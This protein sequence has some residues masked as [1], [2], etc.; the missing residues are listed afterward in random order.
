MK[1]EIVLF[2]IRCKKKKQVGWVGGEEIKRGKYPVVL[3][4]VNLTGGH[5]KRELG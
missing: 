1:D 4:M 3:R 5:I 2:N